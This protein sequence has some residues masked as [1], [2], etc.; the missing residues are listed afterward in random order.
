MPKITWTDTYNFTKEIPARNL[1]SC[2]R[3][4]LSPLLPELFE[5]IFPS[6]S[7]FLFVAGED[8]CPSLSLIASVPT[9]GIM[10]ETT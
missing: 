9:R 1:S 8:D 7:A 6:V 3:R 2:S 10:T 5:G 4:A